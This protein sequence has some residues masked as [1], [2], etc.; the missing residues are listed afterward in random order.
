[1]AKPDNDLRRVAENRKARHEYELLETFEAGL[2]LQGSEVKILRQGKGNIGE[3]FVR[4]IDGEAWLV[5]AHMPPYPQAGPHNNHEP[6]R[7]R[8]LL[9]NAA[10]L[11]KLH[12]R[13]NEKGLTVVPLRLYFKGPW[14]KLEIALARGRKD[15]D[16][17]E[18][19]KE[20]EDRRDMQRAL[21]RE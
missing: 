9:L 2:M 3:A 5:N 15:H 18:V 19:L 21:R 11:E 10:E 13:V 14:V 6:R 1:M 7:P 12:K 20:R 17:R 8:K 4:L 16:K